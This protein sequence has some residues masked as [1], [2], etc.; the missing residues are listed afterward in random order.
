[1][2]EKTA[3]VGHFAI[4]TAPA[5][6]TS[7][8]SG[9][10]NAFSAAYVQLSAS[11]PAA[12][13]ITGIYVEQAAVSAGT[14]I[15]VQ[16]ATGAAGAETIV[17][18]HLIAPVTGSTVA[19]CYKPIYPPIPVANATRIACKTADSVGSLASLIT[20]ECINQSN[21]VDDGV[22][23]ATVT[24]V[25]NQLTAAQIATGVWQD[26][27]AGDF[28]TASSIGK[29]LYISNVAPGASGGHMI[30]GSNAGTTTFG[31]LTVTGATT[32]TGNVALADG[33]TISAPS[34]GNRAGLDIAGNGTGAAVKLTAGATGIGFS[35][36][37]GATSG[38]GIKVTTTSGH[39]VNL[40]PVGTNMHGFLSTGGN[41]GVS[42]GIKAAAG[43]G[44]VDFRANITGN[45]TGN[46]SGS[47]GSVTGAV[48]SVTGA[49]GSVTG[50][51]GSVTGNVGGNIVGS[52]ASVTAAVTLPTIPANWIT[53][54]GINAAALNGKGDWLLSSGYTAP[55]SVAAIRTE[56]DA[57]STGLAAI[58]ARTDVA[59]STRLA[60]SGYTAP[61][62]TSVT[63]IKAKT[64]IL[65][66]T[67]AGKLDGNITAVN[68]IAVT[69]AGT[70]GSP[71]GP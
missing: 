55:P 51:V 37:G 60:T 71:W 66:F 61:D 50:A 6:G 3:G 17:G 20:L 36:S 53:A 4:P 41:G 27:T 10:A 54:T 59:T 42:D 18:Q 24:T 68:G 33:L 70:A 40:A 28:T 58:F 12:L 22:A 69:G 63:A 56:I 5:A 67:V 39:G 57:N 52:V 49:V 19:R 34:T 11:A 45:V 32:L 2:G 7:C 30:A 15:V 25:T 65:T 23:V 44:G 38:D 13:F 26:A 35:V 29:A 1:M 16:L 48:G 14:Y 62:N 43:T 46:L 9:A 64:D 47:A 8:T 21:V 31:A